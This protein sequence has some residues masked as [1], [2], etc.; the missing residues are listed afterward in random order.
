MLTETPYRWLL[1]WYPSPSTPLFL[2]EHQEADLCWRT[3]T[4]GHLPGRASLLLTDGRT[5]PL[6]HPTTLSPGITCVGMIYP[7]T[8]GPHSVTLA[9]HP[10]LISADICLPK[11]NFITIPRRPSFP[12]SWGT[13][14]PSQG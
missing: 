10:S 11:F 3:V 5:A 13:S 14:C 8:T 12:P 2:H 1:A 6:L 9:F 4:R 7:V